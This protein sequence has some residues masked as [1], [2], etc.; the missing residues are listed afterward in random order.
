MMKV[1]NTEFEW[2]P[3]QRA[4]PVQNRKRLSG[5]IW[6]KKEE[7]KRRP[8]ETYMTWKA[9]DDEKKASR[10]RHDMTKGLQAFHTPEIRNPR[11]AS[12]KDNHSQDSCFFVV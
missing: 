6:R 12:S 10:A 9:W 11:L 1:A 8:G 4:A 7:A 5:R 2:D 3:D